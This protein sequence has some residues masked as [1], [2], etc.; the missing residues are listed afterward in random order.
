MEIKPTFRC[1]ALFRSA[2]ADLAG[3]SPDPAH[4][5]LRMSPVFRP[6]AEVL[7]VAVLKR[8]QG[9]R[10]RTYSKWCSQGNKSVVGSVV[11]SLCSF[12]EL[13]CILN[14][15]LRPRC[16]VVP[17]Y[18]GL[19]CAD[20]AVL[21]TEKVSNLLEC[22]VGLCCSEASFELPKVVE[23]VCRSLRSSEMGWKK[24][25]LL[26]KRGCA[27][28]FKR[29]QGREGVKILFKEGGKPVAQGRLEPD[30]LLLFVFG[31]VLVLLFLGF[32]VLSTERKQVSAK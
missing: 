7:H 23:P 29:R 25:C 32:E 17:L 28:R 4:W 19:L 6:V 30:E 16:T 8:F 26:I 11:R 5:F 27:I 3:N 24:C 14:C 22:L 15:G 21:E 12:Q 10:L 18:R 1:P 13:V 31:T 9:A 20:E 2:L